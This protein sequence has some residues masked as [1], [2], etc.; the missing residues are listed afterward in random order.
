MAKRYKL[1]IV[2][3]AAIDIEEIRDFNES[4]KSG[5]G[6]EYLEDILDCLDRIEQN[7]NS[8]QFYRTSKESVRRGLTARF[9]VVVLYEINAE[10]NRVEILT[11]ADSKQN[12]FE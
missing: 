1:V 10:I 7:P 6:F 4:R 3:E 12:W 9:S 5:L 2:E 8:F 11:V